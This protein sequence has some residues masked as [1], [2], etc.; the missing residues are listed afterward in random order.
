LLVTALNLLPAGQLDGGH[1]FSLLFGRRTARRLFPVL[2]L[3]TA[4]LGFLWS[5]WWLWSALIFFFGRSYAEPLDDI[6]PLNPGRKAIAVL[7]LLVFLLVF[8]PVPLVIFGG[9]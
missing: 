7:A 4:L 6:T 3:V 5:G 8:T 1:I 9:M 2:I